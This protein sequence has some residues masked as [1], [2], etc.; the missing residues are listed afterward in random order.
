MNIG[1]EKLFLAYAKDEKIRYSSTSGGI[2]TQLLFY[3]FDNKL[4]NSAITFYFSSDILQYRPKIITRRE[5]YV[6]SE[7]IY[8][9]ISLVSFIKNNIGTIKSPF[10]CF[11]L[12]C[13]TRAIR[14]ILSK[15]NIE[16]WLIELTCSSQQSFEATKYLF[17]RLHIKEKDIRYYQY[18]GNGWP[19]GIQIQTITGQKIYIPNNGSIWS[20]IFHSQLFYM[21]RCFRCNPDIVSAADLTIADPWRLCNVNDEKI[22]KTLCY[23]HTENTMTLLKELH[24]NNIISL[25][26]IPIDK[27]KYSQYGTFQR[28][29]FAISNKKINEIKVRLFTSKTYRI[30]VLNSILIFKLHLL[31]KKVV[32]K[33]LIK[34]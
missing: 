21:K 9:E 19:S 31:L 18:R 12:P 13:Q 5:D 29:R 25:I 33:C 8:H 2:G 16:S 11:C 23:V 34:Y 3:L 30:L 20:D 17:K 28:K 32:D 14:S 22:G 15:N 10:L 24:D 27:Y 26:E 6:N 4:I 7:S 1:S